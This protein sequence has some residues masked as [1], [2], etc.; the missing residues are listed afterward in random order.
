MGQI[1]ETQISRLPCSSTSLKQPFIDH[2]SYQ[3]HQSSP[4]E[5][6]DQLL[7]RA[8]RI[9]VESTTDCPYFSSLG[10]GLVDPPHQR[11]EKVARPCIPWSFRWRALRKGSKGEVAAIT[12]VLLGIPKLGWGGGR[13]SKTWP[14]CLS[15]ECWPTHPMKHT[16]LDKEGHSKCDCKHYHHGDSPRGR[17]ANELGKK[18]EKLF[19]NVCTVNTGGYLCNRT[20][21]HFGWKKP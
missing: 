9:W 20:Q 12:S 15:N 1:V 8:L 17:G 11:K 2:I 5:N 14:F 16:H 7:R 18:Q 3:P 4:P 19:S 13:K 10:Q 21:N 6:C